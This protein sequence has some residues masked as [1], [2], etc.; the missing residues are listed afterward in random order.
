[1]SFFFHVRYF[2]FSHSL[3]DQ[4]S[5]CTSVGFILLFFSSPAA[6]WTRPLSMRY[7]SIAYVIPF[8]W[9]HA[10]FFAIALHWLT[11]FK[12]WCPLLAFSFSFFRLPYFPL[13]HHVRDLTSL[14]HTCISSFFFL[15]L[16]CP[17]S[18]RFFAVWFHS[19]HIYAQ[20]FLNF[21]EFFFFFVMFHI[22]SPSL[23]FDPTCKY[24]CIPS[25]C[26]FRLHLLTVTNVILAKLQQH[27]LRRYLWLR[28]H[29]HNYSF[30]NF[31]C[32][33][34]WGYLS[35]LDDVWRHSHGVGHLKRSHLVLPVPFLSHISAYTINTDCVAR[36]V[37]R[38][39]CTLWVF[40]SICV[41][42]Y[43]FRSSISSRPKHTRRRRRPQDIS[44]PT[45]RLHS[46]AR[47]IRILDQRQK[48]FVPPFEWFPRLRRC[49]LVL[50][51]FFFFTFP[52]SSIW[53]TNSVVF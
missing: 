44:Q 45:P 8:A 17:H 15:E 19:P 18:L 53:L 7:D 22:R 9:I 34:V 29:V 3:P 2:T 42:L 49:A 10:S 36:V 52:S 5:L 47:Q 14:A 50:V 41:V 33:F 1:M 4:M 20:F 35:V 26:S 6:P 24:L 43:W 11:F 37:V 23:R 40:I 27:S 30:Q 31:N 32:V 38:R 12:A 16:Q 39:W 48:T 25:A 28:P 46:A 51:F 13:S 21:F